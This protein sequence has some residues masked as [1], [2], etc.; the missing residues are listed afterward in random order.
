MDNWSN[1]IIE[2]ETYVDSFK[3]DRLAQADFVFAGSTDNL[4]IGSK[5]YKNFR[6]VFPAFDVFTDILAISD[7]A[8]FTYSSICIPEV[9]SGT[10]YITKLYEG[11]VKYKKFEEWDLSYFQVNFETTEEEIEAEVTKS[12]SSLEQVIKIYSFQDD[13]SSLR[14]QILTSNSKYD[15]SLMRKMLNIEYDI[16]DYYDDIN[17]SFDYIPKIYDS[18]SEVVVE[19]A[20]SIY[21]KPLLGGQYEFATGSLRTSPS[22]QTTWETLTPLPASI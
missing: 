18:E 17:L 8:N 13:D 9:L 15:R 1:I 5:R 11:L 12:F 22:Q 16:V 6:H 4:F 19:G 2:K 21:R 20:K 14:F 7:Y 3:S 10:R